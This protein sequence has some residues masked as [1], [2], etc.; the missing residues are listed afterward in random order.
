MFMPSKRFRDSWVVATVFALFS[1]VSAAA[2]AREPAVVNR[3]KPPRRRLIRILALGAPVVAIALGI[4]L[5][6]PAQPPPMTSINDPFKTVDFSDLPPVRTFPA[7][8]G[9]LLAYREY[10][11]IGA[12]RGSVT[13]IHG[14]S[15]SSSS[16]HPIAKA[17]ARAGYEVFAVDVRGH[18]RSGIKGHIGFVG[19]LESDLADFVRVVQPPKPSTLVGFSSGGGFVLRFAGSKYQDNFGSYLLLSPFISQDAPNQSPGSGGWVS[20]GVPRIVALSVLNAVGISAFNSLPV[21]SFALNEQARSFLTTQ[22]DFNLA[23]NF[24]PEP[25]YMANIRR[26]AQPVRILAGDA[27][28]VFRTAELEGIF[29][30]AGKPWDVNLLPG[31][32][33]IELTLRPAAIAAIVHDVDSLQFAGLSPSA[34]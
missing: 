8:D 6:G 31:I 19:Q 32:G 28:E 24:R 21:M 1:R 25:D 29:R 16:M 26:V 10:A 12:A 9:Q 5:G 14:S 18:G 15:A 4:A 30:A 23:T 2:N 13:L 27:D 34:G 17:L 22:Y 7:T 3:L 11:P 33:H 20:V